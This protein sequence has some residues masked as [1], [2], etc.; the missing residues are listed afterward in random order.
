MYITQVLGED[1]TA[2]THC[3]GVQYSAIDEHDTVRGRDWHAKCE[4]GIHLQQ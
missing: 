2:V 3:G 1:N 4:R